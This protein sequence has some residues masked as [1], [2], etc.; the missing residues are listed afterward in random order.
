MAQAHDGAVFKPCSDLKAIGQTGALHDQRM[1]AGGK[2][3]RRQTPKYAFAFVVHGAHFAVHDILGAD[4]VA[5]KSLPDGL[6][7]EANA[8]KRDVCSSSCK[9]QGQANA[10]L[11]RI[12]RT[13]RQHD[14]RGPQ[15]HD[16]LHIKRVIAPY[17]HI[18]AKLAQIMHE[19]VGK[20][21]IVVDQKQH[22]AGA[23]TIRDDPRAASGYTWAK[24]CRGVKGY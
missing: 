23:L 19:I 16:C 10:R 4:D 1:I 5:A 9:G 17:H 15:L 14:R 7:A 18:C 24:R 12:A 22:L 8:Q 20:T 21:V 6:V 13:G 11:R 3:G 2:E